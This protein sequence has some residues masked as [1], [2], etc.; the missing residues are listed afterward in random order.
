MPTTGG[1]GVRTIADIVQVLTQCSKK[2]ADAA[3]L[4]IC[5]SPKSIAI[6]ASACGISTAAVGMGGRLAVAGISTGGSVSLGGLALGGAGLLGAKRFCSSVVK[7]VSEN[8]NDAGK[9]N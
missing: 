7:Q 1:N 9:S 2:E 3:E 4:Q 8:L 5:K 6:L